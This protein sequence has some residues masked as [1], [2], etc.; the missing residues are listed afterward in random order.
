MALGSGSLAEGEMTSSFTM[1]IHSIDGMSGFVA[2][3]VLRNNLVTSGL[4]S[5]RSALRSVFDEADDCSRA[6]VLSSTFLA[7]HNFLHC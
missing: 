2:P 6:R 3:G 4:S 5:R 7:I 1:R